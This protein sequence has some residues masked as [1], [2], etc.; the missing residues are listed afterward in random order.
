MIWNLLLWLALAY[1]V[2]I[3]VWRM[4]RSRREDK[5]K[6]GPAAPPAPIDY[7]FSRGWI[8][9]VAA[10]L[11]AVVALT[12]HYY[13]Q[14]NKIAWTPSEQV[15]ADHFIEAISLYQQASDLSG[16][17]GMPRE[18]WETVNALLQA[19]LAEAEQVSDPVLARID[20]ELTAMFK[21]NFL[22]GLRLGTY[23][24]RYY[25]VP[26]Q[27]GKDTIEHHGDDSIKVS[28]GLLEQWNSWFME[29]R[30]EIM[31]RLE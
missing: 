6:N 7:L 24:L 9:P 30:S 12:F 2:A 31:D 20:P 4:V 15:E 17:T 26:G 8:A 14:W 18:D 1:L 25:T 27:T 21:N 13:P 11:L 28:R 10:L 16:N 29:H 19:A 22:P 5:T 23:G 3:I